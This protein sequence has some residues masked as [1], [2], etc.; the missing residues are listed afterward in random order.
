MAQRAAGRAVRWVRHGF[1]QRQKPVEHCPAR[2]GR[3]CGARRA[4]LRAAEDESPAGAA[5]ADPRCAFI[6]RLAPDRFPATSG[7]QAR[8]R[9]AG[10]ARPRVPGAVHG[11]DRLEVEDSLRRR[12]SDPSGAGAGVVRAENSSGARQ[13]QTSAQTGTAVPGG[14]DGADHFRS[15]GLLEDELGTGA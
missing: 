15:A 14:A 11:A 6:R 8:L 5:A 1:G 9:P 4:V 3:E 2:K 7:R 10:P 12:S 13:W